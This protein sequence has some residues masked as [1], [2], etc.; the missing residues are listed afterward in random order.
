[1][2]VFYVYCTR[3]FILALRQAFL[4]EKCKD[5]NIYFQNGYIETEFG[6]VSI[7]L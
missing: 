7:F 1:M 6:G 5:R 3:V 4:D 2:Y